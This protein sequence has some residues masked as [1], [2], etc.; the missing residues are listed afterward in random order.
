MEHPEKKLFDEVRG[1]RSDLEESKER[2]LKVEKE[3]EQKVVY[4]ESRCQIDER[5]EAKLKQWIN[6]KNNKVTF[7]INDKEYPFFRSTFID[8]VYKCNS[9]FLPDGEDY[10][11][12]EMDKKY[13]KLIIEIIRKGHQAFEEKLSNKKSKF[14]TILDK[15][16]KEDKNF[17]ATLKNSFD[18]QSFF[19]I[20]NDFNLNYTYLGT[21]SNEELIEKFTVENPYTQTTVSKYV[22][23]EPKNLGNPNSKKGLFL[24][25]NG[26]IDITLSETLRTNR[27]YLKPFSADA[28]AFSPLS[29]ASSTQILGSVDGERY[30]LLGLIPSDWGSTINRY[31]LTE[32]I[33]SEPMTYK[34]LRFSNTSAYFSLSYVGFTK[35]PTKK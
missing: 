13:F 12:V 1:L 28:G 35:P 24:N 25:Y 23:T 30:D 3:Y 9:E 2:I 15:A 21:K 11:Y 14:S 8:N 17:I 27:I 32:V 29:G 22:E 19:E 34:Y 26:K 31:L 5:C 10:I 33:F 20:V 6:K 18:P 16:L 7:L 4:L